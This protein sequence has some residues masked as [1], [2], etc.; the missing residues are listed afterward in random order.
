MRIIIMCL[1]L[2]LP[3]PFT[4]AQV[5]NADVVLLS[6]NLDLTIKTLETGGAPQDVNLIRYENPADPT[7]LYWRLGSLTPGFQ[8]K[9][10]HKETFT[11]LNAEPL[12]RH[13][14]DVYYTDGS[15]TNKVIM[16]VPGGAW[17]QGDKDL[18]KT[19]GNTLAGF[20][21]FTVA[22]IN[23]RLSNDEGGNAL[24]P[25]HIKDVATAFAWLKKNIGSRGDPNK[26]YLF[27]QS[28]GAHLASLLATDETWLNAVGY[29]PSDIRAVISM[30]G[31]YFLPD[32]VTYPSN[33]LGLTADE[34]LMYKKLMQ[35][36]FGGWADADLTDPSPQ[37]HISSDQPPFLVIY[38]YNDLP[39]FALEAENFVKAVR[40]LNPMPEISLRAIEFSDYTDDVWR[41]AAAQAA[42]EPTMAEFVGH[43][44]EV[45]AIN[46]NEPDGY[47][48]KLV[49]EFFQ[50]H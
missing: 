9:T 20:H 5:Y 16:F 18:Y 32:L 43:W 30:S 13:Q 49:V 3:V 40:A 41:I 35:D 1:V 15:T 50:S 17:R 25:D 42:N 19:L 48:T 36:A 27:G 22:V 7:V 11:Y 44:A 38:T 28:A 46:P 39:G 31:A 34:V 4:H 8:M 24:H 10:V 23:Y 47:V 12:D 2:F 37:M 29:A 14:L 21:D 6:P 45:I 26:M 33:P